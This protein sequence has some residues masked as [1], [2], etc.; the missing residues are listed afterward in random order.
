MDWI[1]WFSGLV[2]WLVGVPIREMGNGKYEEG[3]MMTNFLFL[4]HRFIHSVR[5]NSFAGF[6]FF[7]LIS[8][9]EI[10]DSLYFSLRNVRK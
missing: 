5:W 2:G 6:S 1:R 3:G 9:R 4:S 10:Y 8:V 7:F